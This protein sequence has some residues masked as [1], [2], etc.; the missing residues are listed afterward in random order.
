MATDQDEIAKD[1][2]SYYDA[3]GDGKLGFKELN[4][5]CK[6]MERVFSEKELK[7]AAME[8]NKTGLSLLTHSCQVTPLL[9][10][11]LL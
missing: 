2:F 6:A 1:A 11:V 10:C 8:I 4:N 3:N 5:A 9:F 7:N